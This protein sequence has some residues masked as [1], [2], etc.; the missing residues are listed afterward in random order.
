MIFQKLAYLFLEIMS[1]INEFSRPCAPSI[2]D[3]SVS[4]SLDDGVHELS[5]ASAPSIGLE[6]S[7]SRPSAPP[8]EVNLKITIRSIGPAIIIYDS[9]PKIPYPWY[10]KN[11]ILR[12]YHP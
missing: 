6:D 2:M 11:N 12:T 10:L 1:V 4:Q 3:N 9:V 5:Q 8:I 7:I